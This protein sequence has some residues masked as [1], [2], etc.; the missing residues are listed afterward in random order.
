MKIGNIAVC[1]GFALALAPMAGYTGAQFRECIAMR[2]ADLLYSELASATALSRRKSD[3]KTRKIIEVSQHGITGIQL[4]TSNPDDIGKI[5][6]SLSGQIQTGECGAKFI[7]IN[8]GCPAPKVIRN[9]A[10]SVLLISPEKLKALVG[11]AVKA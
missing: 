7:D 3:R 2:G 5:A 10:G 6:E 4:F 1:E 8:L 9:G 11:A